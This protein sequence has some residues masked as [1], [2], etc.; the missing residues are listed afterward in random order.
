MNDVHL[1]KYILFQRYSHVRVLYLWIFEMLKFYM[2]D[3]TGTGHGCGMNK[4]YV[5]W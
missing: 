2:F 4:K 3:F 1:E 5:L